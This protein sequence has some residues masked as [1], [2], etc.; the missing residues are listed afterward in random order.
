ML[1]TDLLPHQF[2]EERLERLNGGRQTSDEF[3]LEASVYS[4][5]GGGGR[6][7]Q[8]YKHF[9]TSVRKEGGAIVKTMKSKVSGGIS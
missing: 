6:V 7:K 8:Q 1:T 4:E 3:E 2:I 5:K 9:V